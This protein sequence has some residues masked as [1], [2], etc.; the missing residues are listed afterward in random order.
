MA[1]EIH[2]GLQV[3][4]GNDSTGNGVPIGDT[5]I[6]ST[7]TNELIQ[8]TP[9]G[10][11]FHNPNN[12]SFSQIPVIQDGADYIL[13]SKIVQNLPS[14]L[15]RS[16]GSAQPTTF[17]NLT[18][19]GGKNDA[20]TTALEL[21]DNFSIK[22]DMQMTNAQLAQTN[23]YIF[24]VT[25][26]NSDNSMGSDMWNVVYGFHTNKLEVFCGEYTGVDPDTQLATLTDLS[27]PNTFHNYEILYNGTN[28]SLKIDGTQVFTVAKSFVFKTFA[29]VQTA[30]P[31]YTKQQF[32]LGIRPASTGDSPFQGSIKNI[33][34]KKAGATVFE[35]PLAND[36]NDISA[37]NL[38]MTLSGS[39][40]FA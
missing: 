40:V 26:W 12:G 1:N 22:W 5:N 6:S 39:Y 17:L 8:V 4:F 18:G 32:H 11:L 34:V 19:G 33:V 25:L 37:S 31:T 35:L 20:I 13:N 3:G 9:D 29:A 2:I 7:T 14:W 38:D 36:G 27:S 10:Y 16:G 28:L 21:I 24:G 23:K 30:H 15:R